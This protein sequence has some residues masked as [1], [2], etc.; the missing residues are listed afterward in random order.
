MNIKNNI[1]FN[2]KEPKRIYIQKKVTENIILSSPKFEIKK[3]LGFQ[4]KLIFINK[5]EKGDSIYNYIPCI[6][7]RNNNSS[8]YIIFFHGNSEDIF[9]VENLG[10][11]FKTN[12]NMNIIIVEYP[13]YSIYKSKTQEPKQIYEDSLTVYKWLKNKF[14]ITN[15][16]IFIYGRSLGTSP[17]IYLASKIQ[18]RGLFLVSAFT[19]MKDIGSDKFCSWFVEDIFKS[20]NYIEQIECPILFIHGEE[21]TLIS[22]SHSEKLMKRAKINNS[23]VYLNQRPKMTHNNFYIFNDII[24]PIKEFISNKNFF[25]EG[26][27]ESK[28]KINEEEINKIITIPKSISLYIESEIF[29]IENFQAFDERK[30][31]NAFY[32]IKLNDDRIALT[33]KTIIGIY[34]DRKYTLDYEINLRNQKENINSNNDFVIYHLFQMKNDNLICCTNLGDIFV[35]KIDLDEYETIKYLNIGI[36]EEIFKIDILTTGLLCC[37][38]SSFIILYDDQNYDK[39]NIKTNIN[40]YVDF[41]KIPDKNLVSFVSAKKLFLN[42]FKNNEIQKP[43]V[44]HDIEFPKLNHILAVTNR[45]VIVGGFGGIYIY[46]HFLNKIK[47]NQISD[48]EDIIIFIHK[49]HDEL[50]LLSTYKGKIIQVKIVE[51]SEIIFIEK[52][53]S[54]MEINS[55]LFKNLRCLLFTND[56]SFTII[57][58]TDETQKQQEG[59]LII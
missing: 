7:I 47:Y 40:N 9:I 42:E 48:P 16:D 13:G 58:S 34:D 11:Y 4:K 45:N 38:S 30:K 27:N 59:C 43:I 32:L 55:I 28:N 23:K 41:V 57:K 50:L 37:V 53:F 39:K 17:A 20:I 8:N 56:K 51:N 6:F 54:T 22:P 33:Y 24:E 14:K 44:S 35:F 10:L 19:S 36:T 18:P 31:E 26:I 25:P 1:T 49:I 52:C 21:D 46:D 2:N 15:K 5:I 3:I 12:L 29:N